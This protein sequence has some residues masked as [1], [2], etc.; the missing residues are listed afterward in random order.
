MALMDSIKIAN[1][2]NTVR[3]RRGYRPQAIPMHYFHEDNL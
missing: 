3:N 1:G 2:N